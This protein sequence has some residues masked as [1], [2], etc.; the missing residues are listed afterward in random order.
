MYGIAFVQRRGPC[1]IVP[2]EQNIHC[3]IMLAQT[4]VLIAIFLL[5]CTSTVHYI[6]KDNSPRG[7]GTDG[8][9]GG[10]SGEGTS[11]ANEDYEEGGKRIRRYE[12]E[13]QRML[14]GNDA[15]MAKAQ[16]RATLRCVM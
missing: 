3:L 1:G 11:S 7:E 9:S 13:L 16:H 6:S 2:N 14:N 8:S 12:Y 5:L 4:G 10:S 15:Q